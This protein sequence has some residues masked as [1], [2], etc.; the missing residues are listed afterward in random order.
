MNTPKK[1]FPFFV[2][3]NARIFMVKKLIV[4]WLKIKSLFGNLVRGSKPFA[5]QH[6]KQP[7]L[8]GLL[9]SPQKQQI[10]LGEFYHR[11]YWHIPL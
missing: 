3:K 2:L 9:S 1:I 10:C 4:E 5:D 6:L 7:L 8:P 11:I